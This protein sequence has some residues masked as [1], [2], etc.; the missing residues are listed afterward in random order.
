MQ[1]TTAT[2][3]NTTSSPTEADLE[4]PGTQTHLKNVQ[5]L[6]NAIRKT[7]G[8]LR[9]NKELQAQ[10]EAQWTSYEAEVRSQFAQQRRQ[11]MEDCNNSRKELNDI[12]AQK[13]AAVQQLQS[14]LSGPSTD[15]DPKPMHVDLA[16]QQY[17]ETMIAGPT[18]AQDDS[19]IQQILQQATAA[20]PRTLDPSDVERVQRWLNQHKEVSGVHSTVQDPCAVYSVQ[21]L[22]L[23]RALASSL[24][25]RQN[26]PPVTPQ[27]A[28]HAFPRTP[29]V[30]QHAGAS[31]QVPPAVSSRL[32]PFPPPMQAT[33]SASQAVV[34]Q[35]LPSPPTFGG[36]VND[37]Y[38]FVGSPAELPAP[39]HTQSPASLPPRQHHKTRVSVKETARPAGPIHT[40]APNVGREEQVNAKRA[41]LTEATFPQ[42]QCA[43]KFVLHDD[44]D[45]E[46]AAQLPSETAEGLTVREED[47]MD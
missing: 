13:A 6:I 2:T 22:E 39:T 41:A 24:V 35:G 29:S 43:Q 42:P 26:E 14:C 31:T 12:M 28:P 19:E 47:H 45:D 18:Q 16:E 9:K 33:S 27:R 1:V 34:T 4:D 3:Q 7:D 17:W 32:R 5:K 15:A 30:M 8:R 44:D 20:G 11:Y 40:M 21:D 46:D 36:T 25:S 38:L 10:R 37:P 23:Q